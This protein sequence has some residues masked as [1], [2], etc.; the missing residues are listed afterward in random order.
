MIVY[1]R[2]SCWRN[3][4]LGIYWGS[5]SLLFLRDILSF[6]F[7]FTRLL[8]TSLGFFAR[9]AHALECNRTNTE[10]SS[11]KF[12]IKTVNARTS[13]TNIGTGQIFSPYL[14]THFIAAN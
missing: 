10:T 6:I 9:G 3:K 4:Q 11:A 8:F 14:N 12:K 1:F 5:G 7:L 13:T 2:Y